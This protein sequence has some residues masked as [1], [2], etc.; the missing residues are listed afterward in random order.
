MDD[1][2][3]GLT[4]KLFRLLRALDTGLVRTGNLRG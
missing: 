4:D 3:C 1:R 2:D